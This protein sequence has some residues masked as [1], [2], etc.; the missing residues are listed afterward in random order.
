[1]ALGQKKEKKH[2]MLFCHFGY[3]HF[4]SDL[5]HHTSSCLSLPSTTLPSNRRSLDGGFSSMARLLMKNLD[6]VM[7]AE[8]KNLMILLMTQWIYC[9]GADYNKRY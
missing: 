1:M 8:R 4:F 3:Q 6:K 9:D 5:C 7:A 2:K